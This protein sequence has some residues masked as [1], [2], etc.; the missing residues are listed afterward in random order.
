MLSSQEN[1]V[2]DFLESKDVETTTRAIKDIKGARYAVVDNCLLDILFFF[3][4]NKVSFERNWL[5]CTYFKLVLKIMWALQVPY[6]KQ[7]C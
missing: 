7:Y 3:I 6:C 5:P 2:T 1:I 4:V